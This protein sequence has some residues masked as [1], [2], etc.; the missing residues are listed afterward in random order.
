MTIHSPVQ[1]YQ[2]QSRVGVCDP[3]SSSSLI[4]PAVRTPKDRI[5]PLQL[6]T[7]DLDIPALINNDKDI[8]QLLPLGYMNEDENYSGISCNFS[9]LDNSILNSADFNTEEKKDEFFLRSRQENQQTNL[10]P[11]YIPSMNAHRSGKISRIRETK[12][13]LCVLERLMKRRDHFL[14]PYIPSLD[15]HQSATTSKKIPPRQRLFTLKY[16]P[17]RRPRSPPLNQGRFSTVF[18]GNQHSR[19]DVYALRRRTNRPHDNL[20]QL[21]IP[22][23]DDDSQLPTVLSRGSSY[24][25]LLYTPKRQPIK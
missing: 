23:L 18:R 24:Q 25:H 16:R 6:R 4:Q 15:D 19:Q 22:S 3:Y 1:D 7:L 21:C 17:N 5:E 10:H 13:N 9:P 11:P 12:N 2:D 20:R 8:P 14:P